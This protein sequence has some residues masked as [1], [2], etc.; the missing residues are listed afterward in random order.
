MKRLAVSI[1]AT[2]MLLVA[3]SGCGHDQTGSSIPT[4]NE[5]PT[6][7]PTNPATGKV[8][9]PGEPVK[10]DKPPETLVP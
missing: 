1:L 6:E 5:L 10:A 7:W 9:K 4:T 8:S 3:N 2:L